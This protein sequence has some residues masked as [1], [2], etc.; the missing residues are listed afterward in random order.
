[1]VTPYL[2]V[3]SE[4]TSISQVWH[5]ILGGKVRGTSM[6]GSDAERRGIVPQ[7]FLFSAGSGTR[8]ISGLLLPCSSQDLLGMAAEVVRLGWGE[9]WWIGPFFLYLLS[10][11]P[12]PV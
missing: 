7:P 5:G 1:M 2:T 4:V 3:C 11:W 6:H 12:P 9:Q 10:S 8:Q